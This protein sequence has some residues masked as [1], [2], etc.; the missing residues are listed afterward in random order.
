MFVVL[1]FELI[2]LLRLISLLS[3]SVF[4]I[5]FTCANLAGKISAVNVLN[6]GEVIYFS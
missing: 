5:K 6:S 3:K 4:I 1:V 2:F